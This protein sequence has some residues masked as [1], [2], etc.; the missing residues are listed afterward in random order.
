MR[1][2]LVLYGDLS[3]LSGGFLYDRFLVDALRRAG[4][5]VD[6]IQLPWPSWP[7]GV[8]RGLSPRLAARLRGWQGDLLL[9]DELAHP[10]LALA[11][12][13]LR[14]ARAIP[15]V[16]IVHHLR[17]SERPAL[18]GLV[19]FVE[20]AYLRSV[21]GFIFNSRATRTTVEQVL[22]R[23][24]VGVVATPGGDR[25]GPGPARSDVEARA[26]AP[27]P[28]RILFAG[29]FIPRKG[30]HTLIA[31]LAG[32]PRES[33]C[34][35]AAGL[36]TADAA[37]A[38]S[39]DRLAAHLG[40]QDRIRFP[41]HLDEPGLAAALR[42]HHVLAIPSSYEGFGIM[43]LEA[44]GFGVVPVVTSAGGS[45]QIVEPG[46]SGFLVDPGDTRGLTGTLSCLAA[47]RSRLCAA[48]LGARARFGR[49]EGWERSMAR[50]VSFLHSYRRV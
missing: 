24:T 19:R 28:L 42:E 37:Y 45:A 25:L 36:R 34:L 6:V 16:A 18:P 7:S 32:L 33:W 9:Q 29:A 5:S 8:A 1:I 38:R 30:L 50:A 20:R 35:T 22:G 3:S 11:N 27:G 13:S 21:D 46:R 15:I 23:R 14:R 49:F 31:A 2:G 41:G 12:R 47:D 43:C 44:Q 4:D 17:I 39:I 48:A 10:T 26:R 40:L